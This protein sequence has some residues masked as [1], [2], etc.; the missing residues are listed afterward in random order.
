MLS[1]MRKVAR[2]ESPPPALTQHSQPSCREA[3]S[4]GLREGIR[5]DTLAT[6]V[7]SLARAGGELV[8]GTGSLALRGGG[9]GGGGGLRW[10]VSD[11]LEDCREAWLNPDTE[12]ILSP[13]LLQLH[14]DALQTGYGGLRTL[15]VQ[16]DLAF[17]EP[18]DPFLQF[19]MVFPW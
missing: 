11:G 15:R 14:R 3:V 18:A 16:K 1:E 7:A 17:P 12:R 8:I 13:S 19:A 9:G 5:S 4:L 6:Q 10:A 2:D